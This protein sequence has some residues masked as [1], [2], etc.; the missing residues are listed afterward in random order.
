MKA[1]IFS[2]LI[3]IISSLNLRNNAAFDF[4]SFYTDLVQQ[5]NTLRTK[6]RVGKLTKLK[7]IADMAQ[8][9][10]DQC[11][12]IKNLKHT[13]DYYLDKPVGQNLYLSTWAQVQQM[14]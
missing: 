4:E 2:C 12:R 9:T 6:H 5:H 14:Y 1:I 10:A 3:L 13:S 8:K 11:A 7:A